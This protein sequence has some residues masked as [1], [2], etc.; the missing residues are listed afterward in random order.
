[1]KDKKEIIQ[2]LKDMEKDMVK[3]VLAIEIDHRT[4]S[5]LFITHPKD[6]RINAASVEFKKQRARL[7]IRLS[8]L[9]GFI[10]EVE[11]ERLIIS[12]LL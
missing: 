3:S 1:M 5:A 4:A 6:D 12:E 9:R 2:Y 7:R 11:E 8:T 10:K